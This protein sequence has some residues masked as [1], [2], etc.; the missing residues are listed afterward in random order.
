MIDNNLFLDE[1][2]KNETCSVNNKY[3]EKVKYLIRDSL[4]V[5]C[6][7]QFKRWESTKIGT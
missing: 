3:D 4:L 2:N 1:N 5:H 7:M 6:Y